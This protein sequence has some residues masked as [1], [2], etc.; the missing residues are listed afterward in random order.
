MKSPLEST[1]QLNPLFIGIKTKNKPIYNS[2]TK[3][4]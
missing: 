1:Y 3:K 2:L 4:K